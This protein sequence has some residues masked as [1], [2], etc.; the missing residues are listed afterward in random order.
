LKSEASQ[1]VLHRKALELELHPVIVINKVDRH[2]RTVMKRKL[3]PFL[4]NIGESTVA[5]LVAMVQGNL[6]AV[7][8]T[9][10]TI[11]TQTGVVA[12]GIAATAL[13]LMRTTV[14]WRIAI[15][16]A[17][18]T[19]VVDYFMH[20]GMLGPGI[21]EAVVTGLG[22]GALSLLVGALVRRVRRARTTTR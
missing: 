7:S 1:A 18:V 10:W 13:L 19:G 6:F 21:T 8:L 15:V 11:A 2:R 22:A 3:T 14:R 9:H 12:G 5:C 4:E 20:P 17:L 16:L